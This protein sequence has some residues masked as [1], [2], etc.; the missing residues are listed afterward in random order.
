MTKVFL[1]FLSVACVIAL[2]LTVEMASSKFIK[3]ELIQLSENIVAP[4][5]GFTKKGMTPSLEFI[6]PAE[7]K[8]AFQNPFK[9]IFGTAN[10]AVK[11]SFQRGIANK[12]KADSIA[13][14]SSSIRVFM[15]ESLTKGG[16]R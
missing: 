12:N 11:K 1:Q 9:N 5:L 3:T 8:T 16:G 14:N 13:E 4:A 10:R 6:Q 15:D 2:I 7:V